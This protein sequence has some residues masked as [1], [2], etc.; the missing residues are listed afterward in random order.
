MSLPKEN[1]DPKKQLE[2]NAYRLDK[3]QEM[4]TMWQD[5]RGWARAVN[6]GK[7]KGQFNKVCL[8]R[9]SSPLTPVSGAK[10][11]FLLVQ[12]MCLSRGSFI[13]CLQEEKGR[14]EC[15]SCICCFS[16]PLTQN[17]Q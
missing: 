17:N 6:C 5:R 10:N 4:V 11:A 9:F 15:P 2:P 1:E 13:S 16:V 3:E 7:D 8:L 12:G 14:S